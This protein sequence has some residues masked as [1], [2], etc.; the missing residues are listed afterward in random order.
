MFK[1]WFTFLLGMGGGMVM[2]G[3]GYGGGHYE[4][5]LLLTNMKKSIL[6]V[7]IELISDESVT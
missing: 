5:C 2:G 4:T 6:F 7:N 1:L 3:N